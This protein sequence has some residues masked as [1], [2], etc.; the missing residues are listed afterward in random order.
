MDK[1]LYT[2]VSGANRSLSQQQIHANNLANSNTQ[3][4]RAD[5]EKPPPPRSWAV[6]IAAVS[7][8]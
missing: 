8:S 3:G 7:R 4:F 5:L 6:V 2:A 1:L